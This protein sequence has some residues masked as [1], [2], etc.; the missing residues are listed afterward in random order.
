MIGT[1]PEDS[2]GHADEPEL[3]RHLLRDWHWGDPVLSAVGVLPGSVTRPEVMLSD[4]GR[5]DD[6]DLLSARVGTPHEATAVQFKL[7]KVSES[8]YYTLMP[9][10]LKELPKLFRQTNALIDLGFHRVVACLIIL[11][12]AR[13]TPDGQFVVGG[14]TETLRPVIDA[15]ITLK[16]LH[17]AA[18][19]VRVDLVQDADAA[20]LT[21]GEIS[22]N[23]IRSAITRRQALQVT[24][25]V[26]KVLIA[27]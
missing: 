5:D 9:N 25:W 18:G 7:A 16:G 23:T 10:K 17:K 4:F 19:L 22:C 8:T 27:A 6:L 11:I 26:A 12:D 24:E 20:P 21:S 2:L 1:S 13:K 15:R 14:L 3:V